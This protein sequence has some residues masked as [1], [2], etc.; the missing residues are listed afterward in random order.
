MIITI[1]T[2][3]LVA[4]GRGQQTKRVMGIKIAAMLTNF[5]S[6][7]SS[8][9]THTEKNDRIKTIEVQIIGIV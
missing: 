3:V 8:T 2:M 6:G 5:T 4:C 1:A 7:T 9:N